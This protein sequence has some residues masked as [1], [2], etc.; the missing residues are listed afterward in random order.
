MYLKKRKILLLVLA[1]V[2]L[3]SA[4]GSDADYVMEAPAEEA[5]Y[6]YVEEESYSDDGVA[7]SPVARDSDTMAE[8][9]PEPASAPKLAEPQE[10]LII[11]TGSLDIVVTD[12]ETAVAQITQMVEENGG[13][14]VN[15][16]MYKYSSSAKTGDMTVRVPAD[17]YT[18]AMEAIKEMALDVEGESGNGQDVTDEYVDLNSRLGNLEAT[19]NR[20]RGFL[21][22]TKNV[23]EALAVN[24]E[25]SRL[26]GDIEVIKGRM[27][28]LSQSAAFS[29]ISIHLTPDELSQPIEVAGWKPQGVAKNAI[30]SLVEA[31][32][33]LISFL[34]WFV[35]YALPMLL[36][37]GVPTWLFVRFVRGRIRIRRQ[38]KAGD[39]EDAAATG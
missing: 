3:L 20:V 29:T 26:E 28:Y 8:S 25:L 1:V 2:L 36:I 16:S 27:E 13:W 10:R 39:S 9:A 33:G 6:A 30:E 38:R 19:A 12:T 11:R 35:I 17:G 22:E 15:S 34:I 18:S 7:F 37:I 32:Q 21:D 23:E 4:C 5:G 14:V 31:V 24:V